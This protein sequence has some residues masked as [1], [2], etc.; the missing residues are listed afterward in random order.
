MTVCEEATVTEDR[1][2]HHLRLLQLKKQRQSFVMLGFTY[3]RPQLVHDSVFREKILL[4]QEESVKIFKVPLI[5]RAPGGVMCLA[6][7]VSL[8]N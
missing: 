2:G 1:P 8:V 4:K 7:P 6:C 5:V 3:S